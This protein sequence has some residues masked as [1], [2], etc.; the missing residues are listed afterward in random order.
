MQTHA[1]GGNYRI[2]LADGLVMCDVWKRTDV[3]AQQGGAWAQEMG[4]HL[5]TLAV[6]ARSRAFAMIFDMA[7]APVVAGPQTSAL[8]GKVLNAWEIA[9]RKVAIVVSEAPLMKLQMQR[10]VKENIPTW[11]K[12]FESGPDAHTWASAK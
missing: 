4:Q 5:M 7:E 12:V 11:G 2:L 10:I 3:D 8:L 1:E 6:A 9:G